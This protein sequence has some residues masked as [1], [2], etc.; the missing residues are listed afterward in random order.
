MTNILSPVNVTFDNPI[1]NP[2]GYLYKSTTRMLD[3]TTQKFVESYDGSPPN[4]YQF[5]IWVY[6][7]TIPAN[8]VTTL[9]MNIV[10]NDLYEAEQMLAERAL[11][12]FPTATEVRVALVTETTYSV[13]HAL[14]DPR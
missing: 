9:E 10:G 7:P 11:M 13:H 1:N 8:S 4:E 5:R 6:L 3:Y 12:L 2:S 14:N